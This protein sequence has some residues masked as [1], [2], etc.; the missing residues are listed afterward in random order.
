MQLDRVLAID[1]WY[2][3][4]HWIAVERALRSLDF[5]SSRVAHTENRMQ[6]GINPLRRAI[7]IHLLS[8][9]SRHAEKI[10]GIRVGYP[11]NGDRKGNH[12][13]GRPHRISRWLNDFRQ[14][15]DHQ[16]GAGRDP[17]TS[18]RPH[19]MATGRHI[20]ANGHLKSPGLDQG[21]R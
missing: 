14:R 19:F 11:V 15:P 3:F 18:D 8:F 16:H 2:K 7:E 20:F 12:R 4:R 9:D 5:H 6:R 10:R 17:E 13:G 1:R 21:R